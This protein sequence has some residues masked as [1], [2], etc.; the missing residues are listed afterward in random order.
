MAALPSLPVSSTAKGTF[1]R[2]GTRKRRL[3]EAELDLEGTLKEA[4]SQVVCI[5][6]EVCSDVFYR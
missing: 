2:D 5:P 1:H 6:L 3:A 4:Q